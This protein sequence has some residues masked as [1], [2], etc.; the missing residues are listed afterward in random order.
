M[1]AVSQLLGVQIPC[2]DSKIR[3]YA[4]VDLLQSIRCFGCRQFRH[5]GMA[6]SA[7]VVLTTDIFLNLG[8]YQ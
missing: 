7:A 1:D 4:I 6:M 5:E 2:K 8:R 3:Y